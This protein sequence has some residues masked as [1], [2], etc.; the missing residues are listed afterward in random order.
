M[1]WDILAWNF[2]CQHLFCFHEE[3][4]RMNETKKGNTFFA[5]FHKKIR[6]NSAS[7][8]FFEKKSVASRR[9]CLRKQTKLL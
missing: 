3:P 8:C 9:A 4:C 5:K 1:S 2:I 7:L 6:N